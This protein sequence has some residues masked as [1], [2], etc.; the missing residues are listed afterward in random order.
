MTK[1]RNDMK[2]NET[3]SGIETLFVAA[4]FFGLLAGA[5]FLGIGYRS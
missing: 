2:D 1:Q 4:I 5:F 3:T